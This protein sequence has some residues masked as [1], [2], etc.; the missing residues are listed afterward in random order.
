MRSKRPAAVDRGRGGA[1]TSARHRELVGDLGRWYRL[2]ARDLPWRRSRDPYAIWVSEIMLQ[3]TRVD[4]ALPYY[5]RFLERFPT[6]A[7]LANC[8]VDEVLKQWSGLGYYRRAR[9]LHDAA[10]LV[11]RDHGGALPA[12]ACE[13]ERLPGVGRYTAGAIASI[14]FGE[15]VPLVDGNVARVLSRVFC[16]EQDPASGPGRRKLWQLAGEL[17]PARAPG[18]LNQALMELGATVCTPSGP[19]C[20]R[21]PVTRHCQ[22]RAQGRQGE[23][24]RLGGRKAPTALSLV[25]VAARLATE[26][27]WLLLRRRPDGLY[28][29]L[30]EPPMI[31]A[32]S[33]TE[34]SPALRSMG[35]AARAAL[36]PAGQLRHLLSHRD[37]AVVVVSARP[38][39]RWRLPSSLPEPYDEAGWL[40]DDEV[41]L[42]ALAR[43]ILLV[44]Q[45]GSMQQGGS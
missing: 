5:Q 13:L 1:P 33:L 34:A 21:C 4:T 42:S 36:H 3:Q 2:A 6:V 14:A 39:R 10:R 38:R 44:A 11:C 23:L 24:P 27:R 9:Q 19:S 29:G 20:E 32:A 15:Q 26:P 25:A 18:E 43:K 28:G 45:E 12:S 31:A 7:A 35:V 16:L 30:W 41:A 17:V 40:G 8:P 22:A 37:L